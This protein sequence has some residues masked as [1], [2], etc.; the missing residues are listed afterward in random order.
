MDNS[1][2]LKKIDNKVELNDLRIE[3]DPC[4]ILYTLYKQLRGDDCMYD[5]KSGH[6]ANG[7]IAY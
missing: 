3:S 6:P 1:L 5:C 4:K 2:E 7:S